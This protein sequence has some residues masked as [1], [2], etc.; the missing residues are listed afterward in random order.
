MKYIYTY[1][2]TIAF[3]FGFHKTVKEKLCATSGIFWNLHN[4]T[5]AADRARHTCQFGFSANLCCSNLI[6]KDDGAMS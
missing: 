1:G 5:V 3:L 4:M 6:F 2:M